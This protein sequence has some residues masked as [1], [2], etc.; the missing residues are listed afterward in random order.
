M[1]VSH[2][3][4]HYSFQ[5]S[6]VLARTSGKCDNHTTF[7]FANRA[8][9]ACDVKQHSIHARSNSIHGHDDTFN[10]GRS[11]ERRTG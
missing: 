11:G 3:R 6:P 10:D 9:L 7:A 1:G 5:N 8:S 2:Q 4:R